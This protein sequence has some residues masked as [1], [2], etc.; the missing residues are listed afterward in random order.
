M[1]STMEENHQI[2]LHSSF[3]ILEFPKH[4][5]NKFIVENTSN[6]ILLNETKINKK[7][8]CDIMKP[9]IQ[10]RSTL[11][12]IVEELRKSGFKPIKK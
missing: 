6:K 10:I 7:D 1:T 8:L 11:N 5:L 12:S 9:N 4:L 3:K 2:N